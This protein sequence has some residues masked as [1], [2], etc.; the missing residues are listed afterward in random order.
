MDDERLGDG[1][2]HPCG[3]CA[4]ASRSG[5]II[6]TYVRTFIVYELQF[7]D[8]S[9]LIQFNGAPGELYARRHLV[10]RSSFLPTNTRKRRVFACVVYERAS[11][12]AWALE[13]YIRGHERQNARK[14]GGE[15]EHYLQ[16]CLMI[17]KIIII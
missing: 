15:R 2:V 12:R 10:P 8:G 4:A 5:Y 1:E 13:M 14:K 17:M 11:E 6:R 3:E 9:G 16:V 7:R